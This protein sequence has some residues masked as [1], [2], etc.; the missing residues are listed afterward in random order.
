MTVR[1]RYAPSPTGHL[2]V[3]SLRTAL[4]NWLF[5]RH[6]NGT[7]LLRIEDTDMERSLPEYTESILKALHWASLEPDEVPVIQSDRIE[8]H[9]EVAQK[10]LDQSLAYRC[11]CSSEEL[12]KRIGIS[13]AHEGGYAYYDGF[14]RTR[15]EVEDKPYAIRFKIPD[16]LSF[17]EFNDLIRGPISF[18]REQLDDFIIVRSDGMPMYNFVVVVD[19]AYMKITHVL[20]GEDHISNTPKQV[21]LYQACGY[22]LPQFAHFSLILGSDGQRLSKR[23]RATSVDSYRHDGILADA[24]CNYLVRLGWSHGDQEI[25]SRDELVSYFDLDHMHKSGAIYDQQKLEWLNGVFIR[26]R[27]SHELYLLLERDVDPHINDYFCNWSSQTLEAF[28]GLYKERVK[29]LKEL[30]DELRLLHE[31]PR[32]YPSDIVDELVKK[33]VT[34]H[35]TVVREGLLQLTPCSQESVDRLIKSICTEKGISPK[36]IFQ[37]LRIALTGKISSPGIALLIELLSVEESVQ[38]ID[39]FLKYL[40][41]SM[42]HTN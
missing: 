6:H 41:R 12:A 3:G 28:I 19:D 13:A 17:I 15:K 4:Y 25:F 14:C 1:V 23:H 5:A 42:E 31:R 40:K 29:T 22:D 24:L 20:R 7:Y 16:T 32:E 33:S 18:M 35:L 11:Y 27:S 10:L 26:G 39:H 9:K 36:Q 21:L 37:P 8:V 34:E 2:H 38:R 30:I